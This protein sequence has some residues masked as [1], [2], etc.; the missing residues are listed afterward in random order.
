M[1]LLSGQLGVPD[2]PPIDV[3]SEGGHLGGVGT[4]SYLRRVVFGSETFI[5]SFS[6]KALEAST[7]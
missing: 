7:R 6:R 4:E 2:F 1:T 3:S 5:S